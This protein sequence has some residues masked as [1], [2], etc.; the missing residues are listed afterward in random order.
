MIKVKIRK[1]GK[2]G[3]IEYS[4]KDM[5]PKILFPD[6]E[7]VSIIESYLTTKRRFQIP[8]SDE[9]DDYR[10]DE[11]VPTLNEMY[12]ALALCTLHTETGFWVDWD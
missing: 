1:G 10:I 9:M 8:E 11:E 4:E 2:E 12:F 7:S 3:T 5:I 6:A